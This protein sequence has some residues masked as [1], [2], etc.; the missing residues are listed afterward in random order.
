M[1]ILYVIG[2]YGEEHLGGAIHRELALEIRARGHDYQIVVPAQ[3]ESEKGPGAEA[4]EDEVP[5][6]RLACGGRS[7]L[8]LVN[9]LG[10]PVFHFPWFLTF[11]HRLDRFLKSRPRFDVLIA[12]GAFPFG[13]IA[14]LATRR[15]RTP[16]LVSVLGGDFLANAAANYGYARYALP[17]YLMRASFR[18]A[19]IIR[20]ISPYAGDRAVALGCH[21]ERL[22]LVQRNIARDTF[23][24]E[25]VDH[26]EFRRNARRR[27]GERFALEGARLVVTVGRLL[28][29]K[30]FDDLVR[31]IPGI[32]ASSG[33]V[34]VIHVGPNRA[35]SRLGDYERHLGGIAR[36]LGVG[37]RLAFA[38]A[39]SLEGVREFLAAADVAAVPSIEEGGNKT[40]LEAAA[41]GTP[42][43][44][45]RTTGNADWARSWNCGIIVEPSSPAELATAIA[46]LLRDPA[47][48]DA[49][50]KN[51][52][53]FANE[54]RTGRVADRM[55]A[56]CCVAAE[57]AALPE[58][59]RVPKELL[60]LSDRGGALRDEGS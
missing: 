38:G 33:D 13:A 41:A 31:A 49:M 48:A 39:V 26:R 29:I 45:T 58:D 2:G 17:R 7:T 6:H 54:F 37:P 53:R 56:L 20:A 14:W 21:R 25:G 42:F 51:G 23:L 4:F 52:V 43:V 18:G 10:Q 44:V 35:D 32:V 60:R 3:R 30:G 46:R 34:R 16:Y 15:S 8:D 11:A 27:V 5:V 28:P 57:G 40:L 59:L 24:P 50:G 12:E 47:E 1:R 36:T 9:R 22:A 55:L 19:A